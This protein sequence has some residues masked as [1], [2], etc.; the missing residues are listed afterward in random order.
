MEVR[1]YS[2]ILMLFLFSCSN[3]KINKKENFDQELIRIN[4]YLIPVPIKI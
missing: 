3:I 2:F 1:K 4:N